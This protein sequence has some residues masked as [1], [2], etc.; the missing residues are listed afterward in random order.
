MAIHPWREA[1]P[2]DDIFYKS[3]KRGG[4]GLSQSTMRGHAAGGEIRR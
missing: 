2:I 1:G 4:N 3:P